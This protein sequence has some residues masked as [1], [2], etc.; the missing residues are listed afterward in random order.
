MNNMILTPETL[1]AENFSPFGQVI[2]C[3][4]KDY[5]VINNGYAKKYPDLALIDTH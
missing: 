5:L 2:S 1:T 3:E 4:Q